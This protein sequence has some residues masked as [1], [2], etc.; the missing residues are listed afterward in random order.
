MDCAHCLAHQRRTRATTIVD[1]TAMCD[2][3][4][5]GT[6]AGV[7]VE[8]VMHHLGVADRE[9]DGEQTGKT[10]GQLWPH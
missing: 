1:G 6:F 4:A 10:T 3:H 7:D 2:R 8:Q 9:A 5:V